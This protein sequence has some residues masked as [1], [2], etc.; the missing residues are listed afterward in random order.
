MQNRV[1][2][3]SI[4]PLTLPFIATSCST[5]L[6]KINSLITNNI[7]KWNL[8]TDFDHKII[9]NQDN[10]PKDTNVEQISTKTIE[11]NRYKDFLTSELST[12]GLAKELALPFDIFNSDDE[13]VEKLEPDY[14]SS[15]IRGR[16]FTSPKSYEYH[17]KNFEKQKGYKNRYLFDYKDDFRIVTGAELL[18][19]NP[20]IDQ[21]NKILDTV[22]NERTYLDANKHTRGWREYIDGFNGSL[23]EEDHKKIN[24]IKKYLVFN[25]VVLRNYNWVHYT[26]EDNIFDWFIQVKD[27]KLLFNRLLMNR[28]L[29]DRAIDQ[30]WSS[31]GQSFF[32][33]IV[34]NIVVKNYI[35]EIDK[36]SETLRISP[37]E[38]SVKNNV[39]LD[40]KNY[41]KNFS[42]TAPKNWINTKEE[43]YL[44]LRLRLISQSSI[45]KYFDS[46]KKNKDKWEPTIVN[47]PTVKK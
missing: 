1:K 28:K 33:N 40:R 38:F 15:L 8:F 20:K 5:S 47:V 24:P 6:N 14:F 22:K 18:K 16:G 29:N 41:Y 26:N 43:L 34:R 42:G 10:S 4:I 30:S 11:S 32:N 3:L 39:V 13:K 23:F 25:T 45:Q 35:F 12:I 21:L 17:F 37:E 27:H 44:F 46:I 19:H 2:L 9:F 7:D 36:L 31:T